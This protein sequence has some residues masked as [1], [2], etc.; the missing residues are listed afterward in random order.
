M[1][2][3]QRDIEI[4][5]DG[6]IC[7]YHNNGTLN[8][9]F[10][11]FSDHSFEVF[12]M[13]CQ[14]WTKN[15]FHKK[16]KEALFFPEYY[17]ENLDAFDDCL[18]DMFNSKFRGLVLIFR[19]FDNLVEEHRPTSEGV[20][21]SISRTSREWLL[22]GHKLICLIQSNDPDLHFPELGGLRPT[23]NRAEWLDANRRNKNAQ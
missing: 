8:E 2:N 19:N 21:D 4:L 20:L 5:K 12:D 6:P 9:D 10:S 7:M 18:G 22:E 15:N 14:T 16:I 13:N 1:K 17:G 3:N 11:W 23:W